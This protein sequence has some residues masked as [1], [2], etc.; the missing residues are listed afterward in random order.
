MFPE[1]NTLMPNTNALQRVSQL[2]L[3]TIQS[4]PLIDLLYI[5]SR[6]SDLNDII[7]PSLNLDLCSVVTTVRIKVSNWLGVPCQVP[8]WSKL[9]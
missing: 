8:D 5:D 2:S 7:R 4:H 6:L 1:L 3:V 9:S